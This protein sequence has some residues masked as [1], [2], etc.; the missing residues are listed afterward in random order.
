MKGWDLSTK[1]VYKN[2]WLSV[3]RLLD[4]ALNVQESLGQ[5]AIHLDSRGLK[6]VHIDRGLI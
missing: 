2:V 6:G 5:K 1:G 3:Y 4:T